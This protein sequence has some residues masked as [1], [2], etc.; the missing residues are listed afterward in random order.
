MLKLIIFL[1][2]VR[3]TCYIFYKNGGNIS[4]ESP[5][6]NAA[7]NISNLKNAALFGKVTGVSG[8]VVSCEGLHDTTI[9]S[10]CL[11]ENR[12]KKPL[13]AEV[14][15]YQGDKILLMP[16]APVEGIGPGCA[17]Y[18]IS[19]KATIKV[20][21]GFIGRIINALGEPIDNKGPLSVEGEIRDLKAVPPAPSTRLPIGDKLDVGVRALNTFTPLCQGQRMGVFS[22]S[23]VG[24]ST[25][26]G[27]IAKYAQAEVNVIALVGERGREVMEFIRNSL[28]EEGLR[29][30]IVIVATGD[31]PPLMRRQAA[32]TAMTVAE[33]FRDCGLQVLMMMDSVTRFAM[34]QREIGL[35]AGEPPTTRGYTPSVFSELPR[36]LERAGT[37]AGKG[38]ITGLFTVLVEGSDMDEPVADAVR[39]ILDGHIVLERELAERGHFPSINILKSVSRAVP[40]CNSD[41][42]TSL[43]NKARSFYA[44]YDNMAELI[45]LG[46]YKKGSDTEVD[47]AIFYHSPIEKFLK[48][49]PNESATLDE[50]FS[51]LGVILGKAVPEDPKLAEEK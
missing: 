36:L 26:M 41:E 23:G 27:M 13:Q 40:D 43:I 34:A 38:A 35:S 32:Y 7:E 10:R 31:E 29:K 39:G 15:G 5:F 6:T 51:S 11:V 42:E 8:L 30:S 22:G 20:N 12:H 33:H 44:T 18:L 21:D 14:I 1:G 48:Q 16:F 50:G 25:L 47:T 17:V 3:Y 24:K 45:R 49:A 2:A 9:G 28:G 46:A 37:C 4:M 19:G